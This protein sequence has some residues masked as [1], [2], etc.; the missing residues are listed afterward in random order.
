MFSLFGGSTYPEEPM[1]YPSDM[2]D[3]Q[4]DLLKPYLTYPGPCR[5]RR[6]P[7]RQIVNAIFYVLRS[8]CQWRPPME[9]GIRPL[10][11]LA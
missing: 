3:E 6:H 11:A 7:L 8:G 1:P 9:D 2:S 4:W 10:L 5:P